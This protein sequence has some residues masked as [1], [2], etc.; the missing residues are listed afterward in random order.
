[1]PI[2]LDDAHEPY[3]MPND[4]LF[5]A[6]GVLQ[7]VPAVLAAYHLVDFMRGPRNRSTSRAARREN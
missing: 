7:V 2:I 5:E 4:L 3:E 6:T 1:V